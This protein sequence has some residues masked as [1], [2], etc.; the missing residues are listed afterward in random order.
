MI[1]YDGH[2]KIR[3][4]AT[5]KLHAVRSYPSISTVPIS[6][7]ISTGNEHE[8]RRLI[9]LMESID[10]ISRS[11][12][13]HRGRPRKRT[14]RIHAD[15]NYD[16]TLLIRTYLHQKGIEANIHTQQEQARRGIKEDQDYSMPWPSRRPDTQLKDSS[17]GSR[18]SEESTQAR[19][20]RLASAFM[21]FIHIG[22]IL[23]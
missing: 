1:G 10:M 9:P 4:R 22:C 21:G 17:A 15:K 14:K 16:D 13:N 8:S 11:I 7:T 20:D 23:I 19:Y 18:P 2:H 5:S 6:I 12:Q 3:R